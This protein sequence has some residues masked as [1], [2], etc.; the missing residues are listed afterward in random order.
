MIISSKGLSYMKINYILFGILFLFSSLAC[1]RFDLPRIQEDKLNSPETIIPTP[2]LPLIIDEN[3]NKKTD[4]N[5]IEGSIEEE[6]NDNKT[7]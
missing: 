4:E 6:R 3:G 1:A 2:T 5:I 7:K